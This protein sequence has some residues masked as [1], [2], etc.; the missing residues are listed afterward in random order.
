MLFGKCSQQ[1][2]TVDFKTAAPQ[3]PS[4]TRTKVNKQVTLL[5]VPPDK[6]AYLSWLIS[7]PQSPELVPPTPLPPPIP[8]RSCYSDERPGD[9]Q[10]GKSRSPVGLPCP[11]QRQ[12]RVLSSV[13]QAG[14]ARAARPSPAPTHWVMMGP[15]LPHRWGR[16]PGR[17]QGPS[18]CSAGWLWG[19]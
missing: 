6:D 11:Q 10:G 4:P 18:A 14:G 12:Q 13:A 19:Q 2:P 7:L 17:R 3:G 8:C 1:Q 9:R 5:S 16:S 15:V